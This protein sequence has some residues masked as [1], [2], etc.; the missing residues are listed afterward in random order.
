MNDG[1]RKA[2]IEL[3]ISPEAVGKGVQRKTDF[4]IFKHGVDSIVF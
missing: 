3:D 2:V 4:R 1:S